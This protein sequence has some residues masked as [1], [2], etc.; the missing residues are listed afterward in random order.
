MPLPL[1][2]I[3]HVACPLADAMVNFADA[4]VGNVTEAFKRKGMY[5]DMVVVFSSE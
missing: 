2:R 4:A 3:N 1:P 5:E